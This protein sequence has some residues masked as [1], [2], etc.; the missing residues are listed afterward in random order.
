MTLCVSLLVG[1][2]WLLVSPER[3]LAWG[4]GTHVALGEGLLSALHLIP[5]GIA[6][7]I[8]RYPIHF[9]YGSVAA[10][11]SFAKKYVPEG[12]HCHAWPV[13]EEILAT[14]P[15][16][17]LQATGYGYLCHLAADTIA[18]NFF[19]PR[20]LLRTSTTKA[21]GHTYWEMRMDAH[22][23]EEFVAR[24]RRVVVDYDHR[25][26]DQLFDE[27]LSHTLFSFQTNRR[28]F[29]GMLRFHGNDH[30]N[31]VFEQVLK[32]SRFDLPDELIETYMAL[33]FDYVVDYLNRRDASTAAALDPTGEV[34]LRLAKK[35]RRVALAQPT[36]GPP[37]REQDVEQAAAEFFPLPDR[38]GDHWEGSP[39]DSAKSHPNL[40]A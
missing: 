17:P 36:E 32:N 25:E 11:I 7:L 40:P 26:A 21:L 35:L 14:A 9:L 20:K 18:H 39:E 13:G 2:S 15:T 16:E 38:I 12:R 22:V 23:G 6:A 27:I 30:W 19:V 29:R 37:S 10:D 5:P 28:I 34:P 1:L 3:V 33:S 24:A 8:H 4:P 31:R